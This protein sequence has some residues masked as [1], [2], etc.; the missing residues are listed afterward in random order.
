MKKSKQV[1]YRILRA[2]QRESDGYFNN[3][4]YSEFYRRVSLYCQGKIKNIYGIT[5]ARL[6][7]KELRLMYPED[8]FII[9]KRTTS[10]EIV[11]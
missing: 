7:V 11:K 10:I 4:G 5:Q 1:E 2:G 3:E 6:H 8:K 9:Q